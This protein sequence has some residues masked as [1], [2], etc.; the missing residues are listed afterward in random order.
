MSLLKKIGQLYRP[1]VG[2]ITTW[3]YRWQPDS[4]RVEFTP[5]DGEYAGQRLSLLDM[6][7]AKA[8]VTSESADAAINAVAVL[9]DNW[10]MVA[11]EDEE[12]VPDADD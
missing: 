1:G 3:T 2:L 6:D 11:V 8:V 10:D 5:D 7:E 4:W 9:R 12:E